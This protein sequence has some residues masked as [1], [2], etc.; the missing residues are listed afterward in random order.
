MNLH[1]H[2]FQNEALV[3]YQ[4]AARLDTTA[5]RWP[6]YCGVLLQEM[7]AAEAMAWYQRSSAL[8][9]EYLPLHI[10][11][12]RALLDQRRLDGAA[13]AFGRAL[14]LDSTT[15]H[16]YLGLGQIALARGQLDS[17]LT[18][19]IRGLD[20]NARYAEIHGLL[21]EVYRR[22]GEAQMARKHAHMAQELPET[23]PLRDPVYEELIHEG[24]SAL[25]YRKR[26]LGYWVQGKYDRAIEAFK[27]AVEIKPDPG[28]YNHLGERLLEVGRY[29]EAVYYLREA[30]RLQPNYPAAFVNLARAQFE[31]GQQTDARAWIDRALRLNSALP[32]AHLQRGLMEQTLGKLQKARQ[33]FERGLSF[34]PSHPELAAGLAWLLATASDPQ[35]RDGPR[36]IRLAGMACERTGYADPRKLDILAAAYA[37]RGDFARAVEMGERAASLAEEQRANDLATE[38]RGRVRLYR[39]GQPYRMQ[40]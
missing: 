29:E 17:S 37:E 11:L 40:M 15:A 5:F 27:R 38:I 6:Y 36:A 12:G 31:L 39:N 8:H 28:G 10:R 25:W 14:E 16:A 26:G 34:A 18:L 2:D 32:E 35:L 9:P 3:C 4:Q 19:L 24:V 20:H 33:A 1:V 7:G 23:T 21:A 13:A 22:L 30:V